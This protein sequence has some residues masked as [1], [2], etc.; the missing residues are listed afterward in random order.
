[1][2]SSHPSS[3]ISVETELVYD[4]ETPTTFAFA[5]AAARTDQTRGS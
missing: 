4:V 3:T 1:M 5:I 2:L